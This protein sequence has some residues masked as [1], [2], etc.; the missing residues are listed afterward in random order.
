M[1]TKEQERKA[2]EQ[3]KQIID[4]VSEGNPANSYIG[5]A[6]EGCVELAESNIEYDFGDSF[7]TRAESAEKREHEAREKLSKANEM[8]ERL[9]RLLNNNDGA[10]ERLTHEKAESDK[11][12]DGWNRAYNEAQA[13]AN[14]AEAKVEE[15]AQEIMKLKAMLFDLMFAQTA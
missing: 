12:C 6:F 3:I 8:I 5:M 13:R 14:A 10:Y 11:A 4:K 2:L 7:K 15:Q 9:N 1:I